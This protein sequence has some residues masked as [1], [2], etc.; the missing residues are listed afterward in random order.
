MEVMSFCPTVTT[1]KIRSQLVHVFVVLAVH[2]LTERNATVC[3]PHSSGNGNG[4]TIALSSPKERSLV[5]HAMCGEQP[6][7]AERSEGNIPIAFPSLQ[8]VDDRPLVVH[9]TLSYH[10]AITRIPKLPHLLV[11]SEKCSSSHDEPRIIPSISH[12]KIDIA[13]L[14]QVEDFVGSGSVARRHMRIDGETDVERRIRV[15]EHARGPLFAAAASQV[16]RVNAVDDVDDGEEVRRHVEV[17]DDGD[18]G[19]RVRRER[20]GDGGTQLLDVPGGLSGLSHVGRQSGAASAAVD[21]ED[22]TLVRDDEGLLGVGAMWFRFDDDATGEEGRRKIR[23]LRC[24][25]S[26]G[27]R[28]WFYSGFHSGLHSGL[29][30]RLHSRL[31][32]GFHSRLHSWNNDRL[33]NW[34]PRIRDGWFHRIRHNGLHHRWN[35]HIIRPCSGR[36]YRMNK[37]RFH[38]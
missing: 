17:G 10:R 6:I 32:S 15:V 29:H 27:L 9:V 4:N 36:F 35:C 24:G 26:S 2:Y 13:L 21:V 37:N 25:L 11:G 22:D 16:A 3:K 23:F 14:E 33:S 38:I 7:E 18:F 34:R 20:R 19:L 1:Q 12:G 31:H 5:V 8:H 30:S 28:S